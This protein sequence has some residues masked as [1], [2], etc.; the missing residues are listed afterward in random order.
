MQSLI[1][2]KVIMVTAENFREY[3]W[4][5]L[6]EAR[7]SIQRIEAAERLDAEECGR[8]SFVGLYDYMSEVYWWSVFEPALQNGEVS[9]IR[10]SFDVAEEIMRS[11]DKFLVEALGIRV[12]P[13]L[14][15][16]SAY[17]SFAGERVRAE[18]SDISE[19]AGW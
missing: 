8:E 6:P 14:I 5:E 12:L 7:E 2:V 11:Q 16:W 9:T 4:Q 13:H 10:R 15:S 1:Q 18:V 3:L 17:K 19:N